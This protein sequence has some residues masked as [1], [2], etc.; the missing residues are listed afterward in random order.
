M[1]VRSVWGPGV[2][3]FCLCLL[4]AGLGRAET[5]HALTL[6]ESIDTALRRS[7]GILAAREEV[8]GAEEL[9]KEATKLFLPKFSTSY[10]YKRLNEAPDFT[11]PAIPIAEGVEI[12]ARTMPMGTRDNYVWD[13]NV[14]QPVFTG[15][16]LLANYRINKLGVA[17]AR[18]DELAAEQ[19][20]VLEVKVSYFR[21]L[22]T[23]R[24]LEVAKQSL[25]QLQ[26][27]RDTAQSFYDVGLVPKSDLLYAEVQ[28]ANGEQ[29]LVQSANRVEQAK[30][31]FNTLLRRDINTP[32]E[33][34]DI[35]YYQ[36]FTKELDECLSLAME[37]RPDIRSADL[38]V[39]QANEAVAQAKSA[40][41]PA[42]SAAANVSRY[43]DSPDVSGSPYQDQDTWYVAAVATWDFWEWG[44]TKNRVDYTRTRVNQASEMLA[45]L[46]DRA[47]LEVKN[48]FLL[49]REAEKQIGVTQ[50]AIEL[51][52][53]N[54]RISEERY[55]EQV[56]TSIDVLDGQTLLTKAKS[57]YYS[58]LADYN[59]SRARLE[60]AMG[61]R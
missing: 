6:A 36:P 41:Y 34:E 10:S 29:F 39:Q 4:A 31:G 16:G 28:L 38:R 57:D 5:P 15:G 61:L 58:A 22:Q 23:Q 8:K 49:L 60:R 35:L 2:S 52:T 11:I 55:K 25:E 27:H 56:A 3:A 42:V 50:K 30:A 44:R 33:V 46:R 24:I 32:V 26:A 47:T 7:P 40:Y 17:I 19:D 12:P 14:A 43:G 54:Y 20:V 1:R 9:R 53:E 13:L 21:I 45:G 59:I 18:D 37:N 51:A 48:A